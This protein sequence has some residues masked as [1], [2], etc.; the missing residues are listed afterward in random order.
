[1]KIA[2]FCSSRNIIPSIKT[3]GTE[4]PT[5]YLAKGLAER[6]HEV[7]VF[8]AKGSK[9]PNVEI[10]NISLTQTC[11]EQKFLNI[12]ERIASFYDLNALSKFFS[13]DADDFD[14][15]QFNSYMFYEIL[16]F[17]RFSKTPVVI[18]INYPHNLLYPY[19]KDILKDYSN[20]CYL[21]ISNFIKSVM[22]DLK[23]LKTIHP[24]IDLNDFKFS[25]EKGKYLLFIGR[26]CYNKGAHT[27]I[28]VAKESKMK[29]IIAGRTDQEGGQE[30]YNKEIKPYLNKNI[31]H[32]GEV[33]FKEKIELY[34]NAIATLFPI[35]W[36]EPFGNV[37]IESMACGTPV[38]AFNRAATSEAIRNK[39][40]G[41]V[42]GNTKEMIASLGVIDKINRKDV[43]AWVEKK[44]SNKVI[45]KKYE[46]MYKEIIEN[47]K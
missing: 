2:L 28:K 46:K 35:E 29:L 10:R 9:V 20:V 27:A 31:K 37:M 30:Y 14:V 18:R 33:G 44:F 13:T 24:S 22:P 47:E 32:V 40:S 11:V 7:V 23:Y 42:V 4:Q 41:Y 36:D 12:Q 5:F 16:P 8:A 26:I 21:P 34:Q 6:G 17:T 19:I 39:K 38:I 3:G 43:R 1:M 25:A 15:I 45:I